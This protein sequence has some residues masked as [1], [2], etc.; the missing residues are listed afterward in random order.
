MR[1]LKWDPWFSPE[2]ETSIAIAWIS[3][4]TLA[5]NYFG[6]SQLFSM[7]SAVGKPLIIDLAT[8]NKTRP[9]CAWVKVE[10]DLLKEHPE[11]VAI[12][13]VNKATGEIR[14]KWVKIQYDY[15][16][17]YCTEC[18]LQGHDVEGC[19]K[20]H[21]ELLPEKEEEIVDK[22]MQVA[23]P[24][25]DNG[26]VQGNHKGKNHSSNFNKLHNHTIKVLQSGKVLGNVQD[27]YRWQN[28]KDKNQVKINDNVQKLVNV[29]QGK[30]V[31][32][33]IGKETGA[34]ENNNK[35]ADAAGG[36]VPV[37][38]NH[39][40]HAVKSAGP[41]TV[42]TTNKFAA[43]GD[44]VEEHD[45]VV[46]VVNV[47]AGNQMDAA[48][49]QEVKNSELANVVGDSE[50]QLVTVSVPENV[51]VD[52]SAIPKQLT[53]NAVAFSSGVTG[54]NLQKRWLQQLMMQGL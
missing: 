9:S 41:S 54:G 44:C 36:N 15:V 24:N 31:D 33:N 52:A 32:K 35:Q 20:L 17:K 53:V 27:L 22:G 5:P 47:D 38:N 49:I 46:E 30:V 11:R 6:E 39:K 28:H 34:V 2:E 50:K 42:Q 3:F 10:V 25:N 45:E 23:K 18:C 4:P 19:W 48:I 14:T 12:Q 43:L 40:V 29:K 13:A 26:A 51:N 7:A 37:D 8:K 1:T 16:P 21:P